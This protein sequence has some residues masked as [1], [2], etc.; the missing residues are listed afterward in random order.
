MTSWVVVTIEAQG[1]RHEIEVGIDQLAQ[2]PVVKH[3]VQAKEVQTGTFVKV[4]LVQLPC[5]LEEYEK[6]RFVLFAWKYAALNPHLTLSLRAFGESYQWVPV[7]SEVAL[8]GRLRTQILRT[9]MTLKPL[10]DW[11]ALRSQKT[12]TRAPTDPSATFLQGFAGLK[13]SAKLKAVTDEAEL[14]RCN[15][16][17][18]VNCNGLDR[19]KTARLL[20]VMQQHGREPKPTKLGSIGPEHIARTVFANLE[21]DQETIRYKTTSGTTSDGLPFVVEAA[22][23]ESS[24]PDGLQLITGCNFSPAVDR[25]CVRRLDSLLEHQMIEEDSSVVVLLHIATPAP[26]YLDR[27]KSVID[28]T[29]DL[30]ASVEK[31]VVNV[32]SEWRK[33]RKLEERDARQAER[34][35]TDR[36]QTQRT[37]TN[38]NEAVVKVLPEAIE[39]ASGGGVCEFSQRDFYYAARQLIQRFTDRELKQKYFDK[40]I[41]EYEKTNGLINGRLRGPRGYLLEPH[42]G[43]KIPLG[44]KAVDEYEIPLHLYDTILYF[45]KKGMESKCAWGEIPERY[46]CAIMACE[47]YAVRAAK[48]LLQAAQRR[49]KMKVFCFH[50]ADPAGYNIARTLSKATGAHNYFVEVIDAGIHLQEALDMRLDVETFFRKKRLPSR[51]KLTELEKKYFEGEQIY[52]G[53]KGCRRVEL[54]ALSADP[55]KFVAWVESKLAEHGCDKK[56]VP[57]KTA[58]DAYSREARD[59][60]LRGAIHD[61]INDCL[62]VEELIG[63]ICNTLKPQI[64]IKAIPSQMKSW[65]EALPPQHWKHYV[66]ALVSD[67]VDGLDAAIRENVDEKLREV[68]SRK[69][70]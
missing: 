15:L 34:R 55:H 8:N 1:V 70:G 28:V 29:G 30:E 4:H 18:L 6:A 23:A 58:I 12:V 42:T 25:P 65:A 10:S 49:H 14:V 24:D 48:A 60:I 41:D 68:L 27:G 7:R 59:S 56:L 37:K 11:W 5:I 53:W 52:G 16:S 66:S 46:D 3:D 61:A 13:R 2:V 35:R 44:T 63:P 33:Q 9:G 69:N 32:T 19:S 57:P 40:V 54:N 26:T 20:E 47:G 39:K 38:L 31:C 62:E 22:F 64:D 51:L 36:L 50:D 43:K 67:G 17:A 45:E 21:V